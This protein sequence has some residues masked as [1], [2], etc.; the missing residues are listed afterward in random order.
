[1]FAFAL[2]FVSTEEEYRSNDGQKKDRDANAESDTK[3]AA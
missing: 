1:M 3:R 2:A